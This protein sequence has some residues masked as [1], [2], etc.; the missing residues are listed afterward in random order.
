MSQQKRRYFD[1]AATTQVRPEVLA[2]IVDVY[3]N[4]HGNP[5]SFYLEG[6]KAEDLLKEARDRVAQ[7]IKAKPDEIFFTSCGTEADNWALKGTAF[8]LQHKGKH[9]ITSK[10]EHHAI[11]HTAEWLEKQGF[12]VTYLDVDEQGMVRPEDV[13]AALRE[14]TILVSIM[15]ANNEVGTIQPIKEIGQICK[16]HKVRFHSDAVQALG[17][18]PIDVEDLGVDLMSFSAHKLYGPK[19]VGA[20][21][22]R[23]GNRLD[24]LLHGGAQERGKRGGTENVA[25]IWAFAQALDLAVADLE[26]EAAR[27]IALRDRLIKAI[28][29][30]IPH[31]K[32]NG[33]PSQR[34]PNNINFSFEFIEGEAML[35]LLDAQGFA[36]SSG[37]AC[38]SASLDPSHVLLA[39]GLPHEI[40]HGSLRITLGRENKQEDVDALAEALPAIIQRLRAMSP[41]WEDWEKGKIKR[42]LIPVYSEI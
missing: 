8:A 13:E 42:S 36:C 22:V 9:I 28:A 24:N 16:A 38:T 10:I 37:S 18:I 11:L 40:A 21:Y 20:L 2:S 15:M 14:D 39:M 35:L 23:R 29:S 26:A 7:N 30:S 34:L 32:L 31:A 33:H 27:Q 41:L 17:A 5:S 19:G 1:H 12:E 3:E 25:L 4:Y 6:H